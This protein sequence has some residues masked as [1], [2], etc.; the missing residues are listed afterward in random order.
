MG[1]HREV[2]KRYRFYLGMVALFLPVA[3]LV[4]WH[5]RGWSMQPDVALVLGGDLEREQFAAE[6]A[7]AHPEIDI[8][9]SSGSNPEYAEWVFETA[10]IP[11]EQFRLDYRAVD[12]VTNFTTLVE[13]LERENID[14][15]YLITSDYHMNRA[16]VVAQIVLGS[17]NIHF[18]P[19]A[20]PSA[21]APE[22]PETLTRSLR[23]G[24]RSLLWVFTG[25]TGTEFMSFSQKASAL[26][27]SQD[28]IF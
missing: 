8:W 25:K 19:L 14:S 17:R 12:T 2:A 11:M 27:P 9:I 15:V 28:S 10:Q 26:H 23:D 20:V 13:D 4:Q 3:W 16:L 7:A 1:A 5:L 21:E 22:A 6:F 24:I 18:K